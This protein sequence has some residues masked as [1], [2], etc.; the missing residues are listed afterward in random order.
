MDFHFVIRVVPPGPHGIGESCRPNR[1]S[2]FCRWPRCSKIKQ[3]RCLERPFFSFFLSLMMYNVFANEMT[4]DRLVST[5]FERLWLVHSF[6]IVMGL[7]R[8]AFS[9]AMIR[10]P[11]RRRLSWRRNSRFKSCAGKVAVLWDPW[12]L[13]SDGRCR[14]SWSIVLMRK[15]QLETQ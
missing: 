4:F 7:G 6:I 8:I 11:L 12:G 3:A 9:M 15:I 10:L 1:C 5:T 13:V 2:W 14:G